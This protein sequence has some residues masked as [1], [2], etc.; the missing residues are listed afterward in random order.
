VEVVQE[1]D[2]DA[3]SFVGL[4]PVQLLKPTKWM[5]FVLIIIISELGIWNERGTR[6]CRVAVTIQSRSAMMYVMSKCVWMVLR[7][8]RRSLYKHE[9]SQQFHFN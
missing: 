4:A 2:D 9:C 6:T 7:K 8:Q 5:G 3:R 1:N